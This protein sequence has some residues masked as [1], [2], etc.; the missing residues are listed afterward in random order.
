MATVWID[1]RLRRHDR[2]LASLLDSRKAVV[3]LT[4]LA[5]FAVLALL[6]PALVGDPTD[7]VARPF[8][9]PSGAHWLGT[10]GRGQDVLWQTVAGAR[11]TLLVGFGVGLAVVVVG[12]IIGGVPPGTWAARSTMC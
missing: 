10:T 11:P 8:A 4:I 7:F 5:A 3:A 9:P 12:A 6:G 2:E 1:P